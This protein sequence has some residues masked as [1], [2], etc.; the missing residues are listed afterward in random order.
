FRLA[1]ARHFDEE[2]L[3]TAMEPIVADNKV[4]I[5]THAGNLYALDAQTGDPQ[6]RFAGTG[7]F[8]NSPACAGGVVIAASSEGYLY[9]LEG[10]SGTLR[11]HFFAGNSRFLGYAQILK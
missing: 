6:W 10:S 11:W 8:L 1:W 3:G 5:A 2:R 4:F 9:A 7:A